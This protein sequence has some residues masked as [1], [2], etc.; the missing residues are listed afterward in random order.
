MLGGLKDKFRHFYGKQKA[1]LSVW[2][3]TEGCLYL[4]V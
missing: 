1:D 2:L 4:P 3:I